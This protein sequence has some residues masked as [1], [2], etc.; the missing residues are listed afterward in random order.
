[1]TVNS[2]ARA[3]I[4]M[5][6]HAE[7]TRWRQEAPARLAVLRHFTW[8]PASSAIQRQVHWVLS[9]SCDTLMSPFERRH[10]SRPRA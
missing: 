7:I 10:R 2:R 5:Q 1:M 8:T 3:R 4:V 6:S 9:P